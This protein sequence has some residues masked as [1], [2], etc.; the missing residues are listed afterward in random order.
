ME[1]M[2]GLTPPERFRLFIAITVPEEVG[3]KIEEAQAELRRALPE[4]TVR[5]ARRDQFHLTLRF[6]GNVEARFTEP[7]AQAVRDACRGF[8][9][10][11][12]HAEGIGF[13]PDARAPRVIWVGVKDRQNGLFQLQQAV[14][15][16]VCNF[17]AETA[18]GKFAGHVTLGR[19]KE[20][21]RAE[22]EVV[23]RL[24][25]GM[26]QRV[27]G[28]WTAANVEIMRSVLSSEGVRYASL[29]TVPLAAGKTSCE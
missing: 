15:A 13:F 21:R 10:F 1:Q 22:T 26:A 2:S 5:W 25:S 11:R 6:L 17:T 9:A 3:T 12:L 14:E 23:G 20:L 8:A 24:V 19:I 16:V 18:E 27:F 4:S 7:L 29:T 28:E